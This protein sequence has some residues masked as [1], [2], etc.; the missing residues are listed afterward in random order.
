M[1]REA[2]KDAALSIGSQLATIESNIGRCAGMVMQAAIHSQ[3][4]VLTSA[5]R[6]AE[7]IDDQVTALIVDIRRMRRAMQA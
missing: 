6:E 2:A 5:I 3:P 7:M 4:S 1:S